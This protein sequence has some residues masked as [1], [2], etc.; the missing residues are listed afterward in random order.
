MV[1]Q[2]IS[3]YRVLQKLGEG[4]MGVVYKAEDLKLERPVALKFLAAHALE[5]P[6]HKTRF[7]RE[8]KAAARLD[9]QNI[10]PVYE[11]DEADGQTFLAMAYLEGQTL[12]DKIAERPLKL[13]EALDIA[14]QTVEG[15]KAAHQKEIV[16]RDIKPANLMVTAEGQVK[17]MDFGLAQLAD[18][19]KLTKTATILGT[20]AYMSPE[21]A[22]REPTDRRTDI[23]SLGVVIYEMITGRL[24]F[25]GE[26]QEAILYAIGNE[27]P[28]PITAMR[29]RVPM[30]LERIVGKALAKDRG[31]RYQ[32]MDDLLV[33]LRQL[34]KTR[35][36]A[37]AKGPPAPA[38]SAPGRKLWY[39]GAAGAA[40]LL[41]LLGVVGSRLTGPSAPGL[42]RCSALS[43][44]PASKARNRTPP[45]PPTATRSPSLGTARI[46]T[47]STSTSRWWA[48]L[49][50]RCGSPVIQLLMLH[51]PGRPT[52]GGSPSSVLLGNAT[53]FA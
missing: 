40:L 49:P 26:R 25:E 50:R 9:H 12:K 11:I 36:L 6:E 14:I 51:P 31:A 47:T 2:N 29:A 17:I 30:D 39:A 8:A 48:R 41:V 53:R 52:A 23:W 27:E 10:C 16:H 13:E 28:E 5:D 37:A 45:S 38:A 1:G 42:K 7:V 46:R 20:P 24:P 43:R 33:D 19:S 4:G 32:H 35:D 22:Q 18:R 44:S 3:H 21:Q 15:L 34:K